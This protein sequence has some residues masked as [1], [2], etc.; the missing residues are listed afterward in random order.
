MFDQFLQKSPPKLNV[1]QDKHILIV[2]D[3]IKYTFPFL[4]ALGEC[5]FPCLRFKG[6]IF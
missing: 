6:L 1:L 2:H 3:L 4:Q 5:S